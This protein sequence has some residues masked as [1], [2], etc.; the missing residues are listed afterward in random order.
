MKM[1]SRYK[2]AA[3]VAGEEVILA[4][5]SYQGTQGI[6]V[7]LKDD[8]NWADILERNGKV[9]NHPLAWLAKVSVVGIPWE[10]PAP[11]VTGV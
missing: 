6:F 1:K 10:K 11:A 7:E 9:R 8:P 2:G 5:G 3:F 4:K